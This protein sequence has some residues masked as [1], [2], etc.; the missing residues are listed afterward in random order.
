MKP[1]QLTQDIFSLSGLTNPNIGCLDIWFYKAGYQLVQYS[2]ERAHVK[3]VGLLITSV[4]T[5]MNDIDCFI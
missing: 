5:A 4:I 2:Y 1:V 3:V